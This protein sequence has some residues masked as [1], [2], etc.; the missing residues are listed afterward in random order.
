MK[1]F[2]TIVFDPNMVDEIINAFNKKNI[3]GSTIIIASGMA[4]ILLKNGLNSDDEVV[5]GTLRKLLNNQSEEHALILTVL[6]D[7]LVDIAIE[8]V[9]EVI[10][11]L[12]EAGTG[13]C[14]SIKL[15]FVK[16]VYHE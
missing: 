1:L 6:E 7:N 15:D 4:S 11:N 13:I 9:E 14:F 10:G 12:E 2:V 5:F 16:G 3:H 8:V